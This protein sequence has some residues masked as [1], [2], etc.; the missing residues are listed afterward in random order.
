MCYRVLHNWA[1]PDTLALSRLM[2]A[3]G[4]TVPAD[5][6]GLSMGYQHHCIA[7]EVGIS[8]HSRLSLIL[9]SG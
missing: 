8:T 3:A 4:I 1:S 5:Y 2:L 9:L 7:M 6:G